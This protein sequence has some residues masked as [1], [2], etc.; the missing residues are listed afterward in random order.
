MREATPAQIARA[1]DAAMRLKEQGPS[2]AA[3]PMAYVRVIAEAVL[4][5]SRKRK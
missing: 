1:F 4:T 5:K 3:D 2:F